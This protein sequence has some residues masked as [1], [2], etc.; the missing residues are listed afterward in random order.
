MAIYDV[1]LIRVFEAPIERVWRAWTDPGD[2]R[3]WWGP[4]GFS[5]PV[6]TVDL[7]V[8]GR[9]F[10]TMKAPP[11]YGGL[12]QHSTWTFTE[13]ERP[14]VIRYRFEF[15]DAAGTVICPTEAGIPEGVPAL[16]E[17]EV[18]LTDLGD[19][20]T[21]LEMTE[22]GYTNPEVRD[23]SAMGLEQCLDKMAAL[24]EV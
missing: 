24:V 14:N 20:R 21:G 8:G 5:C 15:C 2:L 4:T 16:G 6:A 13:L 10:A 17:H 1:H 18:L 9:I 7:R 22:R 19:G 11:E 23:L 3:E 12:E